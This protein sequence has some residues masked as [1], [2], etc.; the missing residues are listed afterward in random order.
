MKQLIGR[1]VVSVLRPYVRYV[2]FSPGKQLVGA[3]L[4]YCFFKRVWPFESFQTTLATG[5]KIAGKTEEDVQAILYCLG[6]LEPNLTR[7]MKE[8]LRPGDVFVITR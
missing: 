8:R 5:S 7:W 4:A 3:V 2:P 6:Y 1:G